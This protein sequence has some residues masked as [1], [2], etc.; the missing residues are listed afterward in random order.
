MDK[1]QKPSN[2]E[3]YTTVRNI[4]NLYEVMHVKQANQL[5][6]NKITLTGVI[7]VEIIPR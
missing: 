5:S 4:Y 6:A 1:V 7:V 3:L 2:C